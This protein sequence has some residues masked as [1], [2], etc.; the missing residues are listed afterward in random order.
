MKR[1]RTLAILLFLLT[2]IVLPG[3]SQERP[4]WTEGYFEDLP[5]SYLEVVSGEG[6]SWEEARDAAS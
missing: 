4:P 6:R 3:K 5:N 2:G 1:M